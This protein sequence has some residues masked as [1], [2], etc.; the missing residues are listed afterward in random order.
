[1]QFCSGREEKGEWGR[2]RS[3]AHS[4]GCIALSQL[5]ASALIL[6]NARADPRPVFF[7]HLR[8]RNS[9]EARMGD[10]AFL[11]KLF[12]TY[13]YGWLSVGV[14]T[15]CAKRFHT[16]LFERLWGRHRRVAWSRVPGW[17]ELAFLPRAWV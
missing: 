13:T 2:G 4:K 10:A 12:V 5:K 15:P 16:T 6:A 8:Y 14:C 7:D 11:F 17:R 9:P 1:M 3:L